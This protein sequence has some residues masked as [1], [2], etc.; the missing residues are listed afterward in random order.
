MLIINFRLIENLLTNINTKNIFF[1]Y[2]EFKYLKLLG[3]INE[4]SKKAIIDT[5]FKILLYKK[6]ELVILCI[7]NIYRIV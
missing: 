2:V 4:M 6:L 1:I 3:G 5:N 7:I